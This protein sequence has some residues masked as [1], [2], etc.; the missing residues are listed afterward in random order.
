MESN[1]FSSHKSYLMGIFK[2]VLFTLIHNQQALA[3]SLL[4]RSFP[5]IHLNSYAIPIITLSV[6]AIT[7]MASISDAFALSETDCLALTNLSS[8]EQSYTVVTCDNPFNVSVNMGQR[9]H[10]QNPNGGSANMLPSD[11]YNNPGTYQYSSGG[12]TGTIKLQNPPNVGISFQNVQVSFSGSQMSV[13]GTIVNSNNFAVKNLYVYWHVTGSSGNYLSSWQRFG[14]DGQAYSSQIAAQSTGTFSETVCCLPSSGATT[15][16]PY[17]VQ[18]FRVDGTK[19]ISTSSAPTQP[20]D[21][22]FTLPCNMQENGDGVSTSSCSGSYQNGF[23]K[24]TVGIN[25][26]SGL[27]PITSY[28]AV[29]FF[30]DKNGNQGQNIEVNLAQINPGESKTLVFTNPTSGFVS[31]FKM[32]MLGGTLQTSTNNPIIDFHTDKASYKQGDIIQFIGKADSSHANRMVTIKIYDPS[33]GFVMLYGGLTNS[34]SVLQVNG[35]DT[36]KYSGKFS[37]N[38]IYNA[39]AFFDD[40]PTYKGKST[41]FSYSP[42]SSTNQPVFSTDK[43]S[44]STDDKVIFSGKGFPPSTGVVISIR[45]SGVLVQELTLFTTSIGSFQTFWQ[46]PSNMQAG[47]YQINSVS[48]SVSASITISI[49]SQQDQTID[50]IYVQ[51]SKSQYQYGENIEFNG[52]VVSPFDTSIP[53]TV[54][55]VGPIVGG[56]SN[57]I[58][59][60]G[61]SLLQPDGSFKGKF[62]NSVIGTG[63]NFKII[64]N[65]GTQKAET[66]FYYEGQTNSEEPQN[67]E[68]VKIAKQFY[69]QGDTVVISGKLDVVLPNTPLLIQI[70]HESNRVQIAGVDVAQDGSYTYTFVADG[71][72]FQNS[73]KYD[74]LV[75]YGPTSKYE[76]SFDF[77]TDQTSPAR[78]VFEVK[79]GSYGTFDVPYTIKGGSLKNIVVDSDNFGL[80]VMIQADSD[81]SVTL[82]LGRSWIDSKKIDGTDDTY[83]VYREGFEVPYEET[84]YQ[85]SRVLTIQFQKGDSTIRIIGTYVAGQSSPKTSPSEQPEPDSEIE[86]L[87]SLDKSNYNIGEN[88]VLNAR[89]TNISSP[90][91][92]A[93]TITDPSNSVVLSRTLTTDSHGN[94]NMDFKIEN[95][96][97]GTYSVSAT[98]LIDGWTYPANSEFK[99]SSQLSQIQVISA[100]GTDQRGNPTDFTRGSMGFVK[101]QVNAQNNIATLITVNVFDS[102]LTSIGVGSLKTTLTTGQSELILSFLIPEDAATGTANIYVNGLSGWASDGGVALTREFT[103]NVRIG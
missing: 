48:G 38:G 31:E 11:S 26:N 100:Q 39:T 49:T 44:Y 24:A 18:A 33:G 16:T 102:D 46:L 45:S 35:I 83:I 22:A 27:F 73:G 12:I 14:N 89:L 78:Q 9:L 43:A 99:V 37:Q 55:I 103:G 75:S 5:E 64:V 34:N 51:T 15:A 91:N 84:I 74:V 36:A 40:E 54:R 8:I 52:Q 63:G 65:Y 101:V 57:N 41:T 61:E 82:D 28:K 67:G 58:V 66:Q 47:T 95:L 10:I 32:Q 72:Y 68:Y 19:L 96:K 92:I 60:V 71:P 13:S 53:V 17:L 88:A 42:T 7:M 86:L 69:K 1:E 2:A 98:S 87:V 90:Q 4:R 25:Y 50:K 3:V 79:A 80:L 30:I 20:T 21:G 29:G 76:A 77:N 70:Y 85:I 6:I 97:T 56:E 59:A 93:I 94:A 23:A 81:G 62:L